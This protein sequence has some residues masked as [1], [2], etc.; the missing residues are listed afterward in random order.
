P[1]ASTGPEMAFGQT[2]RRVRQ[3]KSNTQLQFISRMAKRLDYEVFVDFDDYGPHG[4]KA[5][6][7]SAVSLHF[8]RSRSLARSDADLV[9]L[10]WGRHVISFSPT[11]EF[12]KQYTGAVASGQD[13]RTSRRFNDAAADVS[14]VEKDLVGGASAGPFDQEVQSALTVRAAFAQREL[15]SPINLLH[16]QST[17]LGKAR[18]SRKAEALLLAAARRFL[19]A[20]IEVVGLP[21]LRPGFHVVL[22]GLDQAF[23]GTWYV[24][25]AG[26][27]FDDSGYRTALTIRRPGY[28]I[29]PQ[30]A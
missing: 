19:T 30:A 13:P 14:V 15:T 12:W 7:P 21:W 1:L 2:V 29:P 17:G 28:G 22:H 25:K 20:Q 16:V 6:G 24:E 10:V 5:K 18:A 27:S 8:E 23:N 4:V 26:H 11:L 9:D 3:Q